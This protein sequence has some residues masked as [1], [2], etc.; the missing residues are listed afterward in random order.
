M[1]DNVEFSVMWDVFALHYTPLGII[2][3]IYISIYISIY[4]YVYIYIYIIYIYICTVPQIRRHRLTFAARNKMLVIIIII[5]DCLF[6]FHFRDGHLATPDII[7][8]VSF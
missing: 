2:L 4:I 7:F 6:G 5:H 8:I 1:K 3:Y